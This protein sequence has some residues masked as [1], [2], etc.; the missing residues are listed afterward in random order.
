M[1]LLEQGR[2]LKAE[3]RSP[4]EGHSIIYK[5]IPRIRYVAR[6]VQ[7]SKPTCEAAATSISPFHIVQSSQRDKQKLFN[8]NIL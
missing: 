2:Q 4:V 3:G 8:L 1:K 5:A 7:H 6:R